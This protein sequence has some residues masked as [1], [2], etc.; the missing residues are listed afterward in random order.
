MLCT[1]DKTVLP[2]EKK[3]KKVEITPEHKTL[4]FAREEKFGLFHCF[5]DRNGGKKYSL[6][7][8]I[9]KMCFGKA[10]KTCF[11]VW[12]PLHVG[13]QLIRCGCCAFTI[14][15][16]SKQAFSCA[17]FAEKTF[18]NGSS[19]NANNRRESMR[20]ASCRIYLI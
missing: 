5:Y 17:K 14:L 4:S 3:E 15:V 18:S 13:N 19:L 20:S 12:Q 6:A 11:D 16:V 1:V 7:F 10:L 9:V 8:C 2:D